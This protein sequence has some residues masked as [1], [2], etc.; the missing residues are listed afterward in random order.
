MGL[1][2]STS[3]F[4]WLALLLALPYAT[5]R[6][7]RLRLLAP[8]PPEAPA[9]AAAPA[10]SAPALGETRLATETRERPELAQPAAEALPAAAPMLAEKLPPRPIEDPSGHALDGFYASLDATDRKVPGAVSRITY[11]GD[12]LLVTDWVTGTLRRKLHERFGDAGHGF[13]LLAAGWP[14]YFH[15]DVSHTASSGWTLSRV[16]GPRADDGL[17][18]LGGV[19]FRGGPGTWARFGTAKRGAF[20]LRASRFGVSYLA[21]P[22]GGSIEV[23]VDGAP[24]GSID[25][26]ADAKALASHVVEVDDA[27][28]AFELRPKGPV[29]AFGV[30]LERDAPGVVLDAIG[31]LGARMRALDESDDAHFAEALRARAPSLVVYEFGI[32]EAE[33]G[34]AYPLADLEASTRRVLAQTRAALPQAG[35]LVVGALDRADL[36]A[37][38]YVSRNFIPRLVAAQR[39]AAFAEGCAFWD[40]FQAMG[41]PG[42]MGRWAQ[43]GLGGKDLAHPSSAGAEIVGTWI[44]RALAAGLASFREGSPP[45]AGP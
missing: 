43:R 15:N 28:H 40:A 2:K 24:T 41:G 22:G 1:S 21:Q 12:S 8:R 25:T 45:D 5:P 23:L 26:A 32:N 42:S 16:V 37:G 39:R 7:A 11:F 29:R 17:Y 36:R 14:G 3:T 31:I 33:D 44:Y 20:G 18:G 35:C 9:P 27:P 38:E 4:A 6:L 19:S 30:W 10:P 34:D 13:L